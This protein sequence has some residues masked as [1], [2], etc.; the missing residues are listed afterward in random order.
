MYQDAITWNCLTTQ[1]DIR[2][3]KFAKQITG[4]MRS[5][6][7]DSLPCLI[8]VLYHNKIE[9]RLAI[10]R[11]I[12]EPDTLCMLSRCIICNSLIVHA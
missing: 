7:V 11:S 4:A 6:I 2:L 12:L 3:G 9:S 1:Q 10:L 5:G 8:S